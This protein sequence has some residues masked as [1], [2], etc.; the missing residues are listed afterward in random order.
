MTRRFGG[1]TAVDD[2]SFDLQPARLTGLIGP[3]GAGKSTV[4][5]LIAGRLRPDEGTILYRGQ[6]LPYGAHHVAR[7]GLGRLFQEVR[8]F[9]SLTVL[10]NLSLGVPEQPGEGVWTA[11]CAPRA[12]RRRSAEVHELAAEA[13]DFVGLSDLLETLAGSLSYGQ[14]KLVAIARLLA[15]GADLLLLDEPASGVN[16][17]LVDRLAKL[18]VELTARGKTLLLVEHNLEL[19]RRV[20]DD[21]VLLDRGACRAAGRVDEVWDGPAMHEV[22]LA[23][24]EAASAR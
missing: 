24:A 12:V 10:E 20:C 6:R 9:P 21:L 15:G 3:N 23:S 7:L 22:Y 17:Q 16:P 18:L 19:V 14:Q 2:L 13:L 4:I 1:N 8:L 11:L 5:N